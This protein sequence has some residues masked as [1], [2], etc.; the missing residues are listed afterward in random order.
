[1]TRQERIVYNLKALRKADYDYRLAEQNRRDCFKKLMEA[2]ENVE[3]DFKQEML[4]CS[5]P[6]CYE[7]GYHEGDLCDD[8]FRK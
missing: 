8:H 6:G 1:M 4:M 7:L 5:Q 3:L 2:V